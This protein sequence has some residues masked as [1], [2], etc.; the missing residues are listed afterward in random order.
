[1]AKLVVSSQHIRLFIMLCVFVHSVPLDEDEWVVF[2]L[3]LFTL[4]V[5]SFDVV[6]QMVVCFCKN[7]GLV[8]NKCYC[9]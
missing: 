3:S 6:E 7:A 5:K 1:M 4:P 9:K 8:L 2:T